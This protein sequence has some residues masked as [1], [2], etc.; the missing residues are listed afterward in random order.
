VRRYCAVADVGPTRHAQRHC[1]TDDASFET[2]SFGALPQDEEELVMASKKNLILRS[3]R[4]GRLEG[5]TI[6]I[7]PN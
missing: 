4:S 3:L 5:R 2:R 6:V 1:T 7:Q